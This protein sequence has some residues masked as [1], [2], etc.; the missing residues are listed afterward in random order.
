MTTT[1]RPRTPAKPREST[2]A[3]GVAPEP[4]DGA[5]PRPPRSRAP[6]G[7]TSAA[8][9]AGGHSGA[10]GADGH[11][12]AGGEPPERAATYR[13]VFAERPYRYL[14]TAQLLSLVGDQLSKVALSA[15]IFQQT[16][17]AALAALTYAISFVP[18]VIGGPLLSSYADVLPRRQ[19]LIFCD[20]ARA[21]LVLGLVIPGMP[22]PALIVLMFAANLLA[23]P[24]SS[25]RAAMMPDLL[26]GDR[27]VVANGL[28]AVVRQ[29]G[30]VAGFLIGGA[31]V[32]LI[33]PHGTLT[34]DAATFLASAAL[35]VIGVPRLPA[36]SQRQS[37][38]SML[39]DTRAG[40]AIIFTNPV[41]RAYVTL[42]W[43]ASAFTYAYEGIAIPW[44]EALHGGAA[45]GGAILAAGP[46]GQVLG[47]TVIS[48]LVTPRTR[49]RLI[50]P[51]AL[52]S[53]V[54]LTPVALVGSSAATLLLIACAG[55]GSAFSAPLNALFVRAVPAEFRGRAFGV[56]Q[57]GVQ[58]AQGSAMLLAG[59]AASWSHPAAAVA[60][61][62]MIGTAAVALVL[63]SMWPRDDFHRGR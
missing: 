7:G 17:S 45:M 16:R 51:F 24:F 15:L 40:I 41:L 52:L 21:A 49:M 11:G 19:V 37:R 6:V 46:L 28:D 13:D 14:F 50:M 63:W 38:F 48:R 47:L 30:Q 58:V 54:A 60:G 35:V 57:A 23:P 62:G 26:P 31:I 34:V 56:A 2:G 44:G 22:I 12:G 53:S 4:A 39:H 43:V 18:W 9:G 29:G 61:S 5:P 3:A 33:G 25:A 42:F 8:E 32:A 20:V 1:P 10:E 59:V 55:F 36:A 27:Y